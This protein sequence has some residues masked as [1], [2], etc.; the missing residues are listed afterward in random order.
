[1]FGDTR[2]GCPNFYTSYTCVKEIN[3]F[4]LAECHEQPDCG[5]EVDEYDF[6]SYKWTI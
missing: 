6:D 5:F 4:V 2:G 3:P 1:M